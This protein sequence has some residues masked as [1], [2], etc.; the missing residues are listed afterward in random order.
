MSNFVIGLVG[1]CTS[2]KTSVADQLKA[3]GF[4]VRQI[5]QE[6]SYVP[7]MWFKITNPDFLIYLDVS[8]ETTLKRR[9]ISWTRAEYEEQV[10]R[11]AHA[12]THAHLFLNTNILSVDQVVE[13]ILTAL[14]FKLPTD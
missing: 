6:H 11:L 7:E 1:P 10:V 9:K 3:K 4:T 8:Y 14:N 2:G 12:R 13:E 5:A